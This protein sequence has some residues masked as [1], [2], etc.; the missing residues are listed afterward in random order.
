[1]KKSARTIYILSILLSFMGCLHESEPKKN[2][3]DFINN[4][5][6]A[7]VKR[8]NDRFNI[9]LDSLA[10]LYKQEK[11]KEHLDKTLEV[12][13]QSDHLSLLYLKD[14]SN[15]LTNKVKTEGVEPYISILFN[16]GLRSLNSNAS[17]FTENYLGFASAFNNYSKDEFVPNAGVGLKSADEGKY[18]IFTEKIGWMASAVLFSK[19]TYLKSQIMDFT[20][21]ELLFELIEISECDF[22]KN[23]EPSL[24]GA[25]EEDSS[26][27]T[28]TISRLNI[29]MGSLGTNSINDTPCD[30]LVDQLQTEFSADVFNTT[31]NALSNFVEGLS[32]IGSIAPEQFCKALADGMGGNLN[33]GFGSIPPCLNGGEPANIDVDGSAYQAQ[34]M[35]QMLSCMDNTIR[36]NPNAYGGAIVKGTLEWLLKKLGSNYLDEKFKEWTGK[37]EHTQAHLDNDDKL[38]FQTKT[39]WGID[40]NS[41]TPVHITKT[42]YTEGGTL[43]EKFYEDRTVTISEYDDRTI[44]EV[45]K[46][47][48]PYVTETVFYPDGSI[49]EHFYDKESSR[50]LY[51]RTWSPPDQDGNR[52]VTHSQGDDEIEHRVDEDGNKIDVN[53]NEVES[54]ESFPIPNVEDDYNF[55]K[56]ICE[57]IFALSQE[58]EDIQDAGNGV[59]IE[60]IDIAPDGYP[61]NSTQIN[62]AM[63]PYHCVNMDFTPVCVGQFR[64]IDD[65]GANCDCS[66][67]HT[68]LLEYIQGRNNCK[69]IQCPYDMK[70][71]VNT[72]SCVPFDPTS[73]PPLNPGEGPGSP[74]TTTPMNPDDFLEELRQRGVPEEL[75][76]KLNIN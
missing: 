63:L 51:M 50:S 48:D 15:H 39:T 41:E 23:G 67:K 66:T 5:F 55:D 22:C 45:Q 7:D 59:P 28:I 53:G 68:P 42:I 57:S 24:G 9:D 62:D 13:I 70:L 17:H 8:I 43:I 26:P 35:D 54:G 37:T 18:L 19:Q 65:L 27:D 11:Y 40:D 71:D 64:C 34:L 52:T 10:I 38:D 1:M 73:T 25:N 75:I 32:T 2:E 21:D 58:L 31:D 74:P 4:R 49:T 16:I 20:L 14:V 12:L 69:I 47:G 76:D 44:V 3:E 72:C 33:S 56:S 46:H 6:K 29:D 36:A 61:L 60:Y 30:K